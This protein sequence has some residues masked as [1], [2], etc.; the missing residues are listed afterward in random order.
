MRWVECVYV[1]IAGCTLLYLYSDDAVSRSVAVSYKSGKQDSFC[2]GRMVARVLCASTCVYNLWMTRPSI[3]FS[4]ASKRMYKYGTGWC[5]R[6]FHIRG[7]MSFCFAMLS[8]WCSCFLLFNASNTGR[9][10]GVIATTVRDR[11]AFTIRFRQFLGLILY[12]VSVKYNH[13]C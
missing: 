9:E 7:G 6:C 1:Y 13:S 10:G 8:L 4:C 12:R 2:S 3:H 11:T 5:F